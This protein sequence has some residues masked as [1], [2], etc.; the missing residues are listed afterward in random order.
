M[1][2]SYAVVTFIDDAADNSDEEMTSE[3]PSSWV[4]KD[5]LHCWWPSSKNVT[6]LITKKVQPDPRDRKW[7]LRKIHLDGYYGMLYS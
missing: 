3:V 6:A 2:Q 1:S 5:E 4:T 7:Q